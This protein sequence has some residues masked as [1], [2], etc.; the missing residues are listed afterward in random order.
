M[1]P[2]HAITAII[3]Q[4]Q[5][6]QNKQS[7]MAWI[8]HEQT[9]SSAEFA[10]EGIYQ[11]KHSHHSCQFLEYVRFDVVPFA[12]FSDGC[13]TPPKETVDKDGGIGETDDGVIVKGNIL[14]AL[15]PCEVV[16]TGV[17]DAV[18][19]IISELIPHH[20]LIIIVDVQAY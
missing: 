9:L 16:V 10:V 8:S 6:H 2:S 7:D 3:S 12:D 18:G 11:T 5:D 19:E 13:S 1:K 20:W 17:D 15:I 4:Q 14:V